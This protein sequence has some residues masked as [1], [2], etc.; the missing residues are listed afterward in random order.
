ML[1]QDVAIRHS[2]KCIY[3]SENYLNIGVKILNK[4][5]QTQH[6]R[7]KEITVQKELIKDSQFR[8]QKEFALEIKK[9]RMLH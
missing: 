5:Q 2:D 7:S 1:S 4:I 8:K 3:G 9:I 6:I